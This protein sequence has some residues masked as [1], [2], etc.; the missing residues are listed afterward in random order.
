[1]GKAA[2]TSRRS[3]ATC[4]LVLSAVSGSA[5]ANLTSF[6]L[7]NGGFEEG[8]GTNP[9][10]WPSEFGIWSG[11]VTALVSASQGAV[12][13]AGSQMLHF[14]STGTTAGP[15]ALGGSETFQTVG[16]GSLSNEINA[17]RVRVTVS[18]WFNRTAGDS[19][20]DT[21]FQILITSH[22]GVAADFPEQV[23]AETYLSRTYS[24]MF[25]DDDT[26]TWEPLSA[27]MS[28]PAGTDFIGVDVAARENVHNDLL[29]P[30][31]EFD[32]HFADS[33]TLTVTVIPEPS[34]AALFVLG[35]LAVATRRRR[36]A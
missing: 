21:E 10:G 16:L 29:P 12:P 11:D 26:A 30:G 1:M 2:A 33:I 32:G 23:V 9:L 28:L 34:A 24:N 35:V 8:S 3:V 6:A 20:T 36:H 22:D 5:L 31:P 19:E 27:V 14:I 4:A 15:T 17:G 7:N 25:S 18:G 13:Y